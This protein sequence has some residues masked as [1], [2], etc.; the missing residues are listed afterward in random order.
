MTFSPL[1]DVI[2]ETTKRSGRGI[3]TPKNRKRGTMYPTED[4][5]EQP[6]WAEVT[7]VDDTSEVE[8]AD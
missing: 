1:T 4:P 7:E 8:R 3:S 2:L 5:N 6:N